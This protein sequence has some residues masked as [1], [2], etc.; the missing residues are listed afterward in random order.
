MT[1]MPGITLLASGRLD[2]RASAFPQAVQL[3]DGDIL[4]S[5]SVGGGA[6]VTGGTDWSRS[7]DNGL[8][9]THAGT[10]APHDAANRMANFLKLSLAADGKA[11]YAYGAEI[12]DDVSSQFGQR[13]TF[14][15]FCKSIDAGKTWSTPQ[16]V[17][18]PVDCPLE[19]SFA[20]VPLR[21]GRLLAPAATLP[22]KDRLGEQ[23][24]VA[25]SDDDGQSW[26]EHATVFQDP[27]AK[28]GFFEHKFSQLSNGQIL[29]TAW[30][31]QLGDYRDL[32]NCYALSHDEGLTWSSPRSTGIAGQTM[33][34]LSLGGN[35]LLVLY[36]RRY[37]QQGIVMNLVTIDDDSW[38][39]HY[40]GLMYDA[41][42]QHQRDADA[43]FGIDEFDDFAFGFPT[44]IQLHDDSILATHWS[45]ENNRCGIRWTKLRVDWA[46]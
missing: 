35:R 38:T 30:N 32:P 14:A 45:V 41:K 15:L 34:T 10:L 20:A 18:F 33:S 37:G 23:V 44:A 25:I 22:D 4:C 16:R 42:F 2:E 39:L 5:Y 29:A 12:S 19:V 21:S 40:E 1:N 3:P 31:V 8:N 6:E 27:N 24:F 43:T 17:P 7:Q 28:E 36:N 26:T 9:W 13:D 46:S 11:V